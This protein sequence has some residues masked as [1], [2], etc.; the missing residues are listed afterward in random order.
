MFPDIRERLEEHGV[1]VSE[2]GTATLFHA[3]PAERLDKIEAELEIPGSPEVDGR[4][5]VYVASSAEIADVLPDAVGAVAVEVDL[6]LN[7]ELG[8]GLTQDWVELV[9]E[10]PPGERGMPVTAASRV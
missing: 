4:L 7:L 2:Q 5:R 10:V 6:D 3:G 1:E 9:Y 8:M